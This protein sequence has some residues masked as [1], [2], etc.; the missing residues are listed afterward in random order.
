MYTVFKKNL[1]QTPKEH[2]DSITPSS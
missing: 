2:R 1:N